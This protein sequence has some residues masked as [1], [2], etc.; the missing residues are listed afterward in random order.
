MTA[1]ASAGVPPSPSSARPDKAARRALDRRSAA[2]AVPA[3]GALA[4]EPLYVLADTII[5]G[6]LGRVPLAGLAVA[7]SALTTIA[8]LCGSLNQVTT[9][10]VAQS[11][12]A[13]DPAARAT[14]VRTALAVVGAL[15]VVVVTVLLALAPLIAHLYGPAADVRAAAVTYLRA[16]AIGLPALLFSFVAVGYVNGMGRTRRVLA[17]VVLANALNIVLELVFVYLF[18]WGVA[19][20]AWG[21]VIAQ[22]TQAGLLMVDV[23][24][25]GAVMPWH[26]VRRADLASFLSA[27]TRFTVRTLCIV[28]VFAMAVATAARLGTRQ[29]AAHQIGEKL[30]NLLALSLDAVAVAAQVLVGEAVGAG[31]VNDARRVG[32][33]LVGRS[34]L[35][36]ALLGT[37]VA[38][39]SG[40]LPVPFTVDGGVRHSATGVL[41]LLAVLLVPGAVAFLYDGLCL[42]LGAYTFLQ[43][44]ALGATLVM[45]P[46][47]AV[48]LARHSL[49]LPFLWAGL[50][51]WMVARAAI[52][53]V[54]FVRGRWVAGVTRAPA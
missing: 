40:V 32:R 8:W 41:L 36:G 25:A 38:A 23:R 26:G 28:G 7:S 29:L 45:V 11:R 49:G 22:W 9:T 12:G 6:H 14:A 51:A 48:L 46:V 13:D 5:V 39:L 10:R 17:V 33:H 52:Q 53:H 21:T 27:A 19:G 47:Y 42:G 3:L 31:D 24:G 16:S 35:V 1:P 30:F 15:A 44:Q 20:S 4:A 18:H 2:L 37:L 43:R 50:V 34:V 54:W